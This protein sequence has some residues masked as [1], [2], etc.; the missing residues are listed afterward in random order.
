MVLAFLAIAC[1]G[2]DP[3]PTQT[4]TQALPTRTAQVQPTSTPRP[5][6][7]PAPQPTPVPIPGVEVFDAFYGEPVPFPEN[8]MMLIETGCTS[9]DGPASGLMRVYRNGGEIHYDEIFEAP[10]IPGEEP[11]ITSVAIRPGASE[12]VMVVCTKEYCGG[13]GVSRP[14]AEATFFRSTDVG[15]S[16]MPFDVSARYHHVL[17][18]TTQG[19]LKAEF[20]QQIAYAL[21]Q[22]ELRPPNIEGA[23]PMLTGDG[24]VYW[25]NRTQVFY[26]DGSIRTDA[27]H[28]DYLTD[29]IERLPGKAPVLSWGTER[30]NE[31]PPVQL[32]TTDGAAGNHYGYRLPGYFELADWLD[33]RTLVITMDDSSRQIGRVPGLIDWETGRISPVADYPEELRRGRNTVRA[34]VRGPFLRVA[35]DGDC[36]HLRNAPSIESE[37]TGCVATNALVK[38][39]DGV[40]GGPGRWVRVQLFDGHAGYIAGE[41]L[42]D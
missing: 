28:A 40:G 34:V 11:Y 6:S 16:W 21:G 13:L 3:P 4:A 26:E 2:D 31:M 5:A 8:T 15:A 17:G 22:Q 42:V 32:L 37:I 25:R 35:I 29:L 9:C 36:V 27:I 1:S 41:Y 23:H 33:Y 10:S 38:D 19:L 18:F 20:G 14:G 30:I 12:I 7:T 39:V 24:R